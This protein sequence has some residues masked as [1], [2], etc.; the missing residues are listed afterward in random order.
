VNASLARRLWEEQDPVGKR[1]EY[2]G[3][4]LRVVGVV[5][6]VAIR[7]LLEGPEYEVLLPFAQAPMAG[8]TLIAN[9][10]TDPAP[11]VA[12]IRGVVHQLDADQPVTN[13]YTLEGLR[14]E[15]FRPVSVALNVLLLFGVSAL[16]L[17]TA[18]I[19]GVVSHGVSSR[20]REIGI[21]MALGAGKR[22]VLVQIL[23]EGVRLA[24]LGACLGGGGA[25]LLTMVLARRVW[26]L[27]APGLPALVAVGGLLVAVTLA[28]CYFPAWRASRVDP[29][30][31]L[32][33]E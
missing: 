7:N 29:I 26:W 8:M 1:I 5:R 6:N 14:T 3:Q 12:A 18:G 21:R 11:F 17:A 19:Y 10:A 30:A 13:A 28:G 2:N 27:A 15:L 20:T 22:R 32:R 33:N 16:L 9:T 23:G 4:R 24:C 31:A 25:I